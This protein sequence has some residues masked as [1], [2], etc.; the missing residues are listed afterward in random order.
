MEKGQS[1]LEICDKGLGKLSL[2]LLAMH[3]NDS[4]YM[5]ITDLRDWQFGLI[6]V[7]EKPTKFQFLATPEKLSHAISSMKFKFLFSCL[8]SKDLLR[9]K[10]NVF[11]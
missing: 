11:W 1:E 7:L 3:E 2:L 10:S 9:Y 5:M 4:C 6:V 8:I